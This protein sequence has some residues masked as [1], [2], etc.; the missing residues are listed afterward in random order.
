[1]PRPPPCAAAFRAARDGLPFERHGERSFSVRNAPG[2]ARA[3]P[4]ERDAWQR[5]CGSPPGERAGPPGGH[6]PRHGAA[7]RWP[8]PPSARR[9]ELRGA[10]R[11]CRRY[12]RSQPARPLRAR[13]PPAA[14]RQRWNGRRTPR[15]ARWT[16]APGRPR[17]GRGGWT[18]GT[19]RP[20]KSVRGTRANPAALDCR[21]F[22]ARRGTTMGTRT[23]LA[24]P[25]T[26][27]THIPGAV[28]RDSQ[29]WSGIF[30]MRR[31]LSAYQE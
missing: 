1:M 20:P 4:G 30:L 25:S 14:L 23:L 15:S 19:A 5:A 17:S 2:N 11:Q 18:D 8:A 26:M 27:P 24:I 21:A 12:D 6:R 29:N 22:V 9:G 28:G 3:P 7:G 13:P 31:R 10:G 16:P